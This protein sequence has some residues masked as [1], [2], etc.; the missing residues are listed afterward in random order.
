MNDIDRSTAF[1]TISRRIAKD[2][3]LTRHWPL[4]GGVSA[5]IHALELEMPDGKQTRFVVRRAGEHEWKEHAEHTIEIEFRLQQALFQRGLPVAEQFLLDTNCEILSTPYAVMRMIEGST[6]VPQSKVESA[7]YCM[8]EFLLHLHQI[9]PDSIVIP[10]LPSREDPVAGA[11][12]YIPDTPQWSALRSA[13]SG[14]QTTDVP[15][16]ILHG[17]FWPGNIIWCEDQIAAV[18]DWEDTA[19]GTPVSDVACCRAEIMAMYGEQATALFTEHYHAHSTLDFSDQPLWDA[20]CGFA[21]LAT[22]HSWGLEAKV[23]AARRSSTELFVQQAAQ[24]IIARQA[25]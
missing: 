10:G 2:A 21:A 25:Q 11:L 5:F 1:Q 18:I 19:I 16:S 3:T 13:V 22:M 24:Q 23:E 7:M 17:D 9:E 14:W 8:S 4:P 15:A 12:L 6:D 20:Y